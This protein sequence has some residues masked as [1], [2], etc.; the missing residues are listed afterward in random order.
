MQSLYESILKSVG[1][2]KA[3]VSEEVVAWI[4]KTNWFLYK[5]TRMDGNQ[6]VYDAEIEAEPAPGNS[7]KINFVTKKEIPDYKFELGDTYFNGKQYDKLPFNIYSVSVNKKVINVEYE[8]LE[9]NDTSEIVKEVKNEVTFRGCTLNKITSVPK[10]CK[11]LRFVYANSLSG[12]Q[13]CRVNNEISGIELDTF[14]VNYN[15]LS[16]NLD[17][18][19]NV[20]IN[21]RFECCP[22]MV[23][24]PYDAFE[25]GGKLFKQ[26]AS[27]LIWKFFQNNKCEMTRFMFI[28]E[29]KKLLG[30]IKLDKKT[31]RFRYKPL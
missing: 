4:R 25:R 7:W 3:R 22:W 21:S 15:G 29:K 8:R 31:G 5:Y 1:S 12:Q 14:E 9:F 27:D 10:N 30:A 26:S 18:F 13:I 28:E 19:K 6:F 24:S 20:K 2:G 23:G 17:K 11:T 16:C